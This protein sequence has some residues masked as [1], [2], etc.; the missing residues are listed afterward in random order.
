MIDLYTWTTPNGRKISIMLEEV[1]LPYRAIPVG[2]GQG[3]AAR[4]ARRDRRSRV[5]SVRIDGDEL[6]A[7]LL[8]LAQ[9][10]RIARYGSRPP[11][12][13]D[14]DLPAVRRRPGVQVDHGGPPRDEEPSPRRGSCNRGSTAD[15]RP[16]RR[17]RRPRPR[18]SPPRLRHRALRPGVDRHRDR[19]RDTPLPHPLHQRLQ[20][21][22]V[23]RR[24]VERDE[25]REEEPADDSQAER[26]SRL[27]APPTPRAIGSAPRAPPWSSS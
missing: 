9:V 16:A 8:V 7:V 27:G 19:R 12:R 22:V 18:R 11:R 6:R 4:P 1:G 25:L 15:G 20:V 14:R 13:H 5:S 21:R 23:D 10:H 17:R 24:Q 3:R 2:P 26:P